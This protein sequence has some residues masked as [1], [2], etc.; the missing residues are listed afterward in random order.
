MSPSRRAFIVVA[1]LLLVACPEKIPVP[2]DPPEARVD[3]AITAMDTPIHLLPLRN[4]FDP[5]GETITVVSITA[6]SHGTAVLNVDGSVDYTPDTG[7]T[8]PDKF[9]VTIIDTSGWE[10]SNEF[11]LSVGPSQRISFRSNFNDY[12]TLQLYMMD[13]AHPMGMI[14]IAQRFR[15]TA[16]PNISRQQVTSYVPSQDGEHLIFTADD[17]DVFATANLFFA[18]LDENGTSTKLTNLDPAQ[19]QFLGPFTLPELAPDAAHA[20]YSSNE[21]NTGTDDANLFDILQVDTANPT[22]KVRVN[23]PLVRG[24]PDLPAENPAHSD[25]IIE[26]F[27]VAPDGQHLIY[28]LRDA[29]GGLPS[30]VVGFRTELRV[31]DLANPGV[32]T[33]LT[34]VPTTDTAG[35][36]GS[37]ANTGFRFIPNSTLLAYT[38][39]YGGST[40]NDLWMVDYANPGPPVKLSGTAV[41]AGVTSFGFTPDGTK[42]IYTSQEHVSTVADLY[43]VS[44]AMPGVSV[45][46]SKARTGE[47]T[48]GAVNIGQDS[49]FVVYTRDDE[50]E[51]VRELFFVDFNKPTV[52]QKI[53]H[54]LR[55]AGANPLE[56]PGEFVVGVRL[57]PGAP[58]TVLYSTNDLPDEDN[59]TYLTLRTVVV[60]QPGVVTEVGPKIFSGHAFAWMDDGDTIVHQFPSPE[61]IRATTLAM[62]RLS[63]PT[64]F[65]RLTPED[66]PGDTASEFQ[67]IP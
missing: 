4:D 54:T 29:D 20:Y 28:Q 49:S 23:S 14:P 3:Y 56:E 1:T 50:I 48:M 8:G 2:V 53:S 13:L 57:S 42:V 37:L 35:V 67:F 36:V 21:L 27:H 6:A 64:V 58:R 51:N 12:F 63:A 38:G 32:S 22:N 52:Q 11:L 59:V 19:G 34:D 39:A 24:D 31:V 17:S 46:L 33:V 5:T 16:G 26:L 25:D 65:T 62:F 30:T 55:P 18:D 9:T 7:Y 60:D 40:K 61:D 43:M 41:G 15:I 66:N 44:L 47:V 10:A 45:R